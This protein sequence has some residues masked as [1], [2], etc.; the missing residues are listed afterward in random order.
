MTDSRVHLMGTTK[1]QIFMEIHTTVVGIF[2]LENTTEIN[3]EK[4]MEKYECQNATK[5]HVRVR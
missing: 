4:I 1:V 2:I 3:K 5:K